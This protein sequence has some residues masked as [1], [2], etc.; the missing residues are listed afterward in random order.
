MDPGSI[1]R[2]PGQLRVVWLPCLRPEQVRGSFAS[3]QDDSKGG[4]RRAVA[5]VWDSLLCRPEGSGLGEC[6]GGLLVVIQGGRRACLGAG[7][8]ETD[9]SVGSSDG[10]LIE[11]WGSDVHYE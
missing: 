9:G 6:C 3:L 4:R 7:F 11:R 8:E 2:L 5:Y 10:K 1:V